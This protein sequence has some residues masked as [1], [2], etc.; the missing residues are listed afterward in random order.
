MFDCSECF[1]S[2]RSADIDQELD[3][4]WKIVEIK[5]SKTRRAEVAVSATEW[6]NLIDDNNNRRTQLLELAFA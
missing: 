4:E 6:I 1:F 3:R 5:I 2:E